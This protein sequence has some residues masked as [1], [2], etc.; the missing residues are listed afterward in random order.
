MPVPVYTLMKRRAL[1]TRAGAAELAPHLA[2]A[3]SDGGPR[4]TLDFEHVLVLAPGFVDELLGRISEFSEGPVRTITIK[5]A[6]R[7][8]AEKDRAVA[9]GRDAQIEQVND[10]D[11][12]IRLPARSPA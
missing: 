6:P 8:L 7:P 12:E 5:N 4:L 9:R 1:V 3:A 2:K 10:S 11:W